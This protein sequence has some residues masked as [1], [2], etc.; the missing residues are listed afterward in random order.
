M[1]KD[2]KEQRK[3]IDDLLQPRNDADLLDPPSR[4]LWQ[5]YLKGDFKTVEKCLY[6]GSE[7]QYRGFIVYYNWVT[8]K[9][10][11]HIY[12]FA[13]RQV[14]I[15]TLVISFIEMEKILGNVGSKKFGF[16][17]D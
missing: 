14:P 1:I 10:R 15:K 8:R 4:H 3:H 17:Y 16:S 12:E 5:A 9:R 13:C 7:D 11:E 6:D 2:N